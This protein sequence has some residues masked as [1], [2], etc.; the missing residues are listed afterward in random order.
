M[1]RRIC[2]VL[3]VLC[4]PPLAP[5]VAKAQQQEPPT[6]IYV[7]QWSVPRAQW[8]EFTANFE[9]NGRPLLERMFADGTIISWGAVAT[10]VH[11]EQGPT[12][13]VWW[14]A[15]SIAGIERVR[16]ELIKIPPT[17]GMLAGKHSDLFLR[18]LLR[19]VH[20]SGPASGYLWGS[21]TTTQPGKGQQWRELIEKYIRPTLDELLANGTLTAFYLQVEHV[22]TQDPGGRHIVFLTP[23][24]EALDK[25]NAAISALLQKR[26][27]EENRA[28]TAAFDEITVPGAHRDYFARIL[29]Y[30]QK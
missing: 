16:E 25:V 9:K 13:A 6:Y 22:H 15:P 2:L 29:S 19:R 20:A 24:A 12:H 3:A 18:T 23:S 10:V 7:A 14:E 5:L 30:A 27:A 26:S 17:P 4:L 8:G 28:I 11:E 21:H 1:S